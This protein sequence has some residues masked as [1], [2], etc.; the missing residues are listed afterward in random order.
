MIGGGVTGV[1]RR[2]KKLT[3]LL[4]HANKKAHRSEGKVGERGRKKSRE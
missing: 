4:N 2:E 3:F 1:H